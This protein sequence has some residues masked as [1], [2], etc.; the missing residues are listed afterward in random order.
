[1]SGGQAPPAPPKQANYNIKDEEPQ[2]SEGAKTW[3]YT[4]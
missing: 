4:I 2:T 3:S 1:M